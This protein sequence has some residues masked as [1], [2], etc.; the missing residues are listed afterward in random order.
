MKISVA[1]ATYNG[2]KFIVEQLQSILNQSRAVDEVIIT[3]DQSSDSTVEL[4]QDFIKS[5]G[6]S[7]SWKC[8]VNEKNLGFQENFKSAIDLTSGDIIFCCDQDDVWRFDRIEKMSAV[9]EQNEEIGL[10][11]TDCRLFQIIDG[12][13]KYIDKEKE[14]DESIQK[15]ALNT[16]NRYLRSWGCLMCVRRDFYDCIKEDWYCGWAHDDFLWEV[17]VLLNKCY[18]F[19]YC[20]VE[21]RIHGNNTSGNMGHNKEKRIHYLEGIRNSSAKLRILAEKYGKD[22]DTIDLYDKCRRMAEYRLNLV[23]DKKLSY[24]FHLLKYL[25]YYHSKKSYLVEFKIAIRG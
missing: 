12:E 5:N 19:Q 8:L 1:I 23:R 3:D 17:A 4:I 13:K 7:P 16:Y 24:F 25:K 21:R 22:T 6:L 2:E 9:I 20:S 10:L 15:I 14:E 11:Y 18:H